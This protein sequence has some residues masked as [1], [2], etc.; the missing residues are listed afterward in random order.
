MAEDQFWSNDRRPTWYEA[1]VVAWLREIHKA[2]GLG[3]TA[4]NNTLKANGEAQ[5]AAI[6]ENTAALKAINETLI[7]GATPPP[8]RVPHSMKLHAGKPVP[9]QPEAPKPPA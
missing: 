4:V 5:V 2:I 3:F 6:K 1:S 7:K 9:E 8:P